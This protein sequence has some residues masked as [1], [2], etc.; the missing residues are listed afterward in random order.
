[1]ASI[2]DGNDI[3]RR[4]VFICGLHRSGTSLVG[5]NIARLE[6]CTGFK[7]TGVTEDEGQ[8]L[9]DVYL[10]SMAYGGVGRFGFDPR[11]HLT[12]TSP[13]LTPEN[14]VRLRQS[15]E[16][17]WEQAKRIRVEKTPGNLLKT[18]FLQA[19]FPDSYFIVVRRHPVPVSMA[20][21]KWRVSFAALHNLFEHWLHCHSLFDEDKKNLKRVYELSYEDYVRDPD[22]YHEEI[23]AFIGTS[24]PKGRMER[25]TGAFNQ[26]YFNRWSGLLNHSRCKGYYQYIAAKYEPRFENYGYSLV[27]GFGIKEEQL[28]K[29]GETSVTVGALYCLMADACAIVVRSSTRSRGYIR[30]QLRA[31]LPEPLKTRIKG[32]LQK[33]SFGESQSDVASV[34]STENS[35]PH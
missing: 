20:S 11:A 8:F 12:E 6:N 29:A 34:R 21:Q 30:R 1:M 2:Q 19:M 3:G 32:V 33:I 23:A 18:R 26:K 31:R 7:D 24:V 4:Y 10:T 28:Y 15:W 22:K 14:A 27:K 5:R 25:V 17:Y 16:R 35:R 9:Q 13:L